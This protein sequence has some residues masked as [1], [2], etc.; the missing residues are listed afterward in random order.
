MAMW[1][2]VYHLPLAAAMDP[3]H[4]EEATLIHLSAFPPGTLPEDL[5]IGAL[6]EMSMPTADAG[7]LLTA[8]S[9]RLSGSA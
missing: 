2:I 9:H 5:P 1:S 4:L 3:L 7:Q 8:T 6:L